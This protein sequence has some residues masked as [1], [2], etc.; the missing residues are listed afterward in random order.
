MQ[1]AGSARLDRQ[2][3]R[4]VT[5]GAKDM[6]T[7]WQRRWCA[8]FELVEPFQIGQYCLYAVCNVNS[9]MICHVGRSS[10]TF[11]RSSWPT[12]HG[13]DAQT[14]LAHTLNYSTHRG[15]Q[16][17]RKAARRSVRN[18]CTRILCVFWNY[19]FSFEILFNRNG[20]SRQRTS[21]NS[22]LESPP[23]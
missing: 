10:P 20:L 5:L 6:E 23:Q 16:G 21:I 9:L 7:L 3:S 17:R 13:G 2:V 4:L 22:R 8:R 15:T 1:S 18:A 14:W 12:R 19:L 11:G